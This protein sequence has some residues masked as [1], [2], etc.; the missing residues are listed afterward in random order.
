V[1]KDGHCFCLIVFYDDVAH[2]LFG[3]IKFVFGLVADTA[4]V[5][6]FNV[7]NLGKPQADSLGEQRKQ[8][9]QQMT[10]IAFPNLL[11]LLIV[12]IFVVFVAV[13]FFG[14]CCFRCCCCCC[15]LVVMV[16][17]VS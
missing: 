7:P 17:S 10:R 11:L 16:L 15:C 13:L 12:I 2:S 4:Q 5:F 8:K 6:L 1:Q 9:F 3:C 14:C